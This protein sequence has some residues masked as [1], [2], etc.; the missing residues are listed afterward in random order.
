MKMRPAIV[1]LAAGTSRRVDGAARRPGLHPLDGNVLATTL[2]HAIETRLPLVVVTTAALAPSAARLVAT[3]DIVEL[4]V[5]DLARGLGHEIATGV[6]ARADA[7]G[8]VVLPANM[9]LVRPLSMLA[10]AA[11]LE[12]HAVAYAQYRGRGGR[13]LGF[14]AELYSE[15]MRLTGDDGARRMVARYPAF[16]VDVDDHG[17]LVGIDTEA[18][19]LAAD[20]APGGTPPRT[21]AVSPA[22]DAG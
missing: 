20:S 17:V 8:W 21:A 9:P 1:V 4:S 14:A 2:R 22:G 10:V 18:E 16:G 7:Q 5:D 19:L 3:R 6:S 11:A 12:L 15:L 13:L